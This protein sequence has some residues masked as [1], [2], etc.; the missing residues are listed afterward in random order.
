ML[1]SF[2]LLLLCCLSTAQAAPVTV[3]ASFSI[4]GDWVRVVGGERVAVQTLIGSNQDAHSYQP[5]PSLAR[6][7]G[8]AQVLVV[9]GLHFDDAVLRLAEAG[10]F[11]GRLVVVSAG[12]TPLLHA[13]AVDPHFF[14]D[15]SLVPQAVAAI[16]EALAAVDPAGAVGYRQRAQVYAQQL[17]QTDAWAAQ[18][19]AGLRPAQRRAIISHDAFAYF[20][21]HFG[22]SLY[23]V[24][25]LNGEAEA[26]ASVVAGLI[27]QIRASGLRAVFVENVSDPRLV[28]QIAAET[29]IALGGVLYSDALTGANG[30]AGDYLHFYRRNVETL[31]AGMRAN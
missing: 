30:P 28:Q 6:E 26:G 18:Q 27:R 7:L 21:R 15:I 5:S 3:V 22:L 20:A 9:N 19:F 8:A 23:P 17:R 29:G 24:Q 4:I 14:Q 25:G 13:G 10:G 2:I 12:V 31:V 16:A 11:H 1:R